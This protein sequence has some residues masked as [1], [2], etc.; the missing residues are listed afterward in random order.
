VVLYSDPEGGSQ[1]LYRLE[2]ITFAKTILR[3]T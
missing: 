2:I 1:M 3:Y